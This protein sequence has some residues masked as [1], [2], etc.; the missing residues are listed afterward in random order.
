MFACMLQL[1]KCIAADLKQKTKMLLV[2]W[3]FVSAAQ[4]RAARTKSLSS[5]K[6]GSYDLSWDLI[7]VNCELFCLLK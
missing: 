3:T 2:I 4:V 1:R 6:T 5:G 7:K